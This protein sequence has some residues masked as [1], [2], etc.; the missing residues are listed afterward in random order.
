MHIEVDVEGHLVV[1][2]DLEPADEQA[3][4][5]VF[6]ACEDWFVAE[7][8]QPSAP[9]DVQSAFYAIP[10]GSDFED[11]VLLVIETGGEVVGFIDAV[12]RYPHTAAVAVG[13]F[14]V[15]PEYRRNGIG[16]AVA[17]ALF[18]AAAE[19]DF[20]QINTHVTQGWEPGRRFLAALG[21]TLSAP[22][23]AR[24]TVDRNVGAGEE[25]AVI[26]ALMAIG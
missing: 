1:V 16:R 15:R 8:G 19:S 17:Q 13:T 7:T 14:L 26:P 12:R 11:K 2:R 20:A 6:T 5:D 22:R 9:G 18:T 25:R 10:E 23:P 21:F 4:L 3:V 24:Q